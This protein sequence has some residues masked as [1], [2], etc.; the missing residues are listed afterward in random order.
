MDDK[1]IARRAR[2]SHLFRCLNLS[3]APMSNSRGE[4]N[5]CPI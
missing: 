1:H 5:K 4:W 2:H 3:L